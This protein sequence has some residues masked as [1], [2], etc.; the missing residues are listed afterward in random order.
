MKINIIGGGPA[1][2]YAAYLLKR[3]R[4]DAMV[5]VYEQNDAHTTFGFGVVF[6][7]QALEFLRANDPETLDMVSRGLETWR[8]IELRIHAQA[9]R[10]DGVGFTAIG[11]LKL[12]EI[13]RQRA[14]S[15]GAVLIN[16]RIVTSL[17]GLDSTDL[18]IGADGV[19]SLVRRTHEQAF[20]TRIDYLDN[21]FAWFGATRP[22]DRLTQAFKKLP[23]GYFNAHYYRYSESMST[24]LVEV[25]AS[26]FERI[27]FEHMSEEESRRYCQEVF[28]D[29]LAGAS[30]VVN[31][32]MWRRF[33]KISN[34]RWSFG[35]RVLVGDALRT[36]HFSIGSGTR[37]A[38]EDVQALAQSVADHP[39]SVPD[40]LASYEAGRRPIVEKITAAAN[41]SADWYDHFPQ[42]M[43]LPAWE[44]AM[45]YI[46][47]SGRVDPER[48]RTMSPE[49]VDN[50][51]RWQAAA[52]S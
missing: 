13:L 23:Q 47:R 14:E 49:F 2:L 4:P 32:S 18:V 34:A 24:F 48:L 17:D 35:N 19:N 1:G 39:N 11:R 30:L 7:D 3:D 21:R 15:V 50:Y 46:G 12:L 42:H 41:Q 44:F 9:I 20:G 8:D 33:P 40:A 26:T 10:I 5:H 16:N 37:L 38:L 31:R 51:D 43:E 52:A 25:D 6:S 27:G 22:F 28:A 29:E 36:A 45:D